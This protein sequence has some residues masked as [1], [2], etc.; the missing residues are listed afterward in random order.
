MKGFNGLS[1]V[2]SS[3]QRSLGSLCLCPGWQSAESLDDVLD[4][5]FL[6]LVEVVMGPN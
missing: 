4:N 2:V 5:K 6:R 1:Q 3:S